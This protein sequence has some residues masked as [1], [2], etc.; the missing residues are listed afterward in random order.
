MD[1]TTI[2][3]ILLLPV[4]PDLP[5]EADLLTRQALK[6]TAHLLQLWPRDGV[7]G[8]DFGSD[9]RW[10]WLTWHEIYG[11][12]PCED[13]NRLP[14][15]GVIEQYLGFADAHCA[16]LDAQAWRWDY[17]EQRRR[18]EDAFWCRDFWRLAY[19][20]SAPRGDLSCG[21]SW[22]RALLKRMR[23]YIGEEA[24]CAGQWPPWVPTWN[25]QRVR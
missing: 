15:F 3:L 14:S 18:E 12:P 13:V 17:F 10:C 6:D 22:R 25:F 9:L 19:A 5:P 21:P 4:E 1:T 23:E 24:Y 20:A 2:L 8:E 16:W 7:W 11:A